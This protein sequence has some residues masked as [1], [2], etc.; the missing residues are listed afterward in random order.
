MNQ[1]DYAPVQQA[2]AQL[3]VLSADQETRHMAERREMA[4][5]VERTETEALLARGKAEGR[6]EGRAEG[7]LEALQ[8]LIDEGIP[9]ARARAMLHLPPP[10]SPALPPSH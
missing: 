5:M 9:E 8:C 1:I 3:H 10:A 2:L 4:L 7:K 6:A